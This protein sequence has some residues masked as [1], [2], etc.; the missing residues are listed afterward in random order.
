MKTKSKTHIAV[1]NGS[2]DV[3]LD[4]FL[5]FSLRLKRIVKSKGQ[6]GV[7]YAV[8][9]TYPDW[10]SARWIGQD[11]ARFIRAFRL[12]SGE[13]A[14]F[15]ADVSETGALHWHGLILTQRSRDWVKERWAWISGASLDA[16]CVVQVRGQVD[17]LLKHRCQPEWSFVDDDAP[18]TKE[19]Q[20]AQ[21]A[22]KPSSLLVQLTRFANYACKELPRIDVPL[23]SRVSASG[24]FVKAWT[25]ATGL[26]L[27]PLASNLARPRIL[28]PV[29][30]GSETRSDARDILVAPPTSAPPSQSRAETV[31]PP[32]G[33]SAPSLE[34]KSRPGDF[35]TTTNGEK[36]PPGW[37]VCLQCKR[38]F[39]ITRRDRMC[40]GKKCTRRHYDANGRTRPAAEETTQRGHGR[41][42]KN[43]SVRRPGP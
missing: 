2:L 23:T 40:C 14:W 12:K 37:R 42:N 22:Q 36:V 17:I 15:V 13:G 24:A 41:G 7:L 38:L 33:T 21:K 31:P 16:I 18:L 27:A 43:V 3:S 8:T 39:E 25:E 6:K 26:D 28:M 10:A 9:L 19:A 35:D 4:G 30:Q 29:I 32:V 1:V 20:K 11:I 34:F 5:A